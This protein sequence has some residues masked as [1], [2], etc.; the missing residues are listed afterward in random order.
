MSNSERWDHSGYDGMIKDDK[1]SGKRNMKQKGFYN[2]YKDNNQFSEKVG[3]P[4]YFDG[5]QSSRKNKPQKYFNKTINDQ[6]MKDDKFKKP[7]NNNKKRKKDND[8]YN[9]EETEKHSFHKSNSLNF[10]DEINAQYRKSNSNNYMN[11]PSNFYNKPQ[12]NNFQNFMS[13]PQSVPNYTITV[14]E[15]EPNEDLMNGE[16]ENMIMEQNK[17]LSNE[18]LKDKKN[19]KNM[20]DT[21]KANKVN[22]KRIDGRRNSDSHNTL[23]VSDDGSNNSNTP[24]RRL[25]GS[26]KSGSNTI[27]SNN[28]TSNPI[29]STLNVM[30]GGIPNYGF[31]GSPLNKD[32]Y[33]PN[34]NLNNPNMNIRMPGFVTNSPMRMNDQYMY[35]NPNNFNNNRNVNPQM[36]G[37]MGMGMSP[38]DPNTFNPHYTYNMMAMNQVKNQQQQEPMNKNFHPEGDNQNFDRR[39]K[40]MNNNQQ[41]QQQFVNNKYFQKNMINQQMNNTPHNFNMNNNNFKQINNNN[42]NFNNKKIMMPNMN[43]QMGMM[44]RKPVKSEKNISANLQR[45]NIE[46]QILNENVRLPNKMW[47]NHYNV[48]DNVIRKEKTKEEIDPPSPLEKDASFENDDRAVLQ[49]VIKLI[50]KEEVINLTRSEDTLKVSKEFCAKN[51]LNDD[52]AKPIQQK[53][54][55]ALKSIDLILDH[56]ISTTEEQSLTEIQNIYN[57]MQSNDSF[58]NLSCITD[59]G[60]SELRL[61]IDENI[62][63]NMSK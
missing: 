50:D 23:S 49:I 7:N 28:M 26:A 2:K 54:K 33:V 11:V 15:A 51:Q 39:K 31:N 17:I 42:N 27:N 34:P 32:F 5:S 20:L 3:M 16:N 9:Y 35:P 62:Q 55:Q 41:Q 14:T 12:P 46:T 18:N 8:S 60:E 57:Q 10:D 25:S 52:L 63:L 45:T 37:M 56:N 29:N 22:K 21:L 61:D 59:I 4:E 43:P 58:L 13:M 44:Y 24:H 19:F 38:I 47:R 6:E 53:I 48:Q 30:P 1:N 40:M 36:M